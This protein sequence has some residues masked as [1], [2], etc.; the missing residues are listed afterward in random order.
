MSYGIV[1]RPRAER[2]IDKA[3]GWYRK[4]DARIATAFLFAVD[5]AIGRVEENP[6]QF[7]VRDGKLRHAIVGGYP[8]S[9]LYF[10]NEPDVVVTNCVHFSRHP[11][12][13]R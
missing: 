11:R 1:L 9:L 6:F 2:A 8:Y 4:N 3:A 5:H 13:W 10:V 7:P 12:H